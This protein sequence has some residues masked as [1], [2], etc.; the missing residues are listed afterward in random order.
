MKNILIV[1]V[2]LSFGACSVRPG[3][4]KKIPRDVSVHS[5]DFSTNVT[6]KGSRNMSALYLGCGGLYLADDGMGILVDPFFS[7]QPA[8]RIGKSVLLGKD[9]KRNL[10]SNKKFLANGMAAVR[11][12]EETE[13][14]SPI[15]IL[16][17]HS[18]YD[19]LMDIP[20]IYQQY[21]R[22]PKLLLP[23][24]AFNIVHQ[25]VDS[26]DVIVLEKR[27]EELD[28]TQDPI[29]IRNGNRAVHV[30]PILADH[31]PHY[32]NLKFFS[33]SQT[34]PTTELKDPFQKTKANLWLEGNVF[35]FI[36]DFMG[37][38]GGID[39]RVFVQSS[40]CNAP[41]GIPSR[42]L[43]AEK[44]VDLAFIGVASYAFSPDYP[45]E[46]LEQISPRE[47]VWIHWEDFFRSYNKPPKTLR[48]TDVPGFFRLPCLSKY[49]NSGKLLWPRVK[50]ELVY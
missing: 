21:N 36:I 42:E 3:S 45:C 14:V 24:S 2:L 46:L 13:N 16:N 37:E 28:A 19:H 25:V 15:A 10:R 6:G 41:A 40:S 44:A 26:D 12:L 34:S 47:I 33:G 29:V 43:L 38:N 17:A 30:Y 5:S 4:I 35:S 27:V 20:A 18:H 32:R 49:K 8:F 39:F 11:K 50:M 31:N 22:Q 1:F 48:G 7:N 23:S 9:G